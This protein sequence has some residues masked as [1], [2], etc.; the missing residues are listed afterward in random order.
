MKNVP[1]KFRGKSCSFDCLVYGNNLVRKNYI[2]TIDNW[3]V[4]L[5]S[6]EKFVGFDADGNAVYQKLED[7]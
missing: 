3:Y 2:A 6:V 5:D 4:Y 1:S 7:F